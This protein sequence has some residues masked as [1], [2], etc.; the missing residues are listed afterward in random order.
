MSS[1]LP[2]LVTSAVVGKKANESASFN[3]RFGKCAIVLAVLMI[4]GYY[5]LGL[6]FGYSLAWEETMYRST[7]PNVM[8][9]LVWIMGIF[10][11][12]CG[13]ACI[14]IGK[15]QQQREAELRAKI[16][17][18]A[19]GGVPARD[20]LE[21]RALLKADGD[22]T[23]VYVLHNKTADKCY[24]GQSS[25]AL[26][27]IAAHLTGRGNGDVYADFKYGAEFEVALIPLNGSGYDSLD[28][29]EHETIKAYDA[30]D[31]GYNRTR[32]NRA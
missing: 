6:V 14:V 18:L 9:W 7:F 5:I 4:A 2:V 11:L 29:L 15:R 20:F 28:E 31:G 12:V 21:N 19:G 24:V 30:F 3:I 1:M 25:K 22:V 13:I 27:R 17:G 16:Y 8:K 32:G 10:F 23:G 26:D